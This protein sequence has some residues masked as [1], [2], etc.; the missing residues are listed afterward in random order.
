MPQEDQSTPNLVI[1]RE[2]LIRGKLLNSPLRLNNAE[3]KSGQ[4]GDDVRIILDD[5]SAN[6]VLLFDLILQVKDDRS[7]RL[8]PNPLRS[9]QNLRL[10]VKDR[11]PQR[12]G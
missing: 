10:V 4:G 7:T 6:H 5:L 8:L 12:I 11:P 3:T 1:Q 2:F 9:R